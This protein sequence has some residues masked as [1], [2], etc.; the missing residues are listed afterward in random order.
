MH[1]EGL[2]LT[3]LILLCYPS[4]YALLLCIPIMALFRSPRRIGSVGVVSAMDGVVSEV[5]VGGAQSVRVQRRLL[6]TFSIMAPIDGTIKQAERRGGLVQL[7][8]DNGQVEVRCTYM[9]RFG[10]WCYCRL[11]KTRGA[12]VVSGETIGCAVWCTCCEVW[13]PPGLD[14]SVAPGDVVL[15]GSSR[16]CGTVAMFG[17]DQAI[18]CAVWWKGYELCYAD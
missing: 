13:I 12:K 7:A 6:D 3:G 2:L 16:L 15:G 1:T 18:R 4:V 5:C 9:L 8:V 11:H 10:S 14:I 17:C